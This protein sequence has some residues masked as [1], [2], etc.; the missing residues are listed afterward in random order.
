MK[1]L[2]PAFASLLTA[3]LASA[4]STAPSAPQPETKCPA[5]PDRLI[6]SKLPDPFTFFNGKKVRTKDDWA[7]RRAEISALLQRFELGDLPGKPDKVVGVIDENHRSIT[8]N[9]TVGDRE[10]SF[11]S[12]IRL[13]EPV[14]PEP[15]PSPEPEPEE[16]EEPSPEPEEPV[17]EPEEPEPTPEPEDPDSVST[18]KKKYPAIISLG[19]ASIPAPEGVAV[20]SLNNDLIA[21]Q[22]GRT[23]SRGKGLFYDLYGADHSAGAMLA[24]TWGVSRLIDALESAQGSQIDTKRLAVTGCSRNGKGTH[25]VGAFEE[26]IALTIPQ[27]PGTGGAGC[28]RIA[29]QLRDEG[30]TVQTGSQ[31]ITENVW[32][33]TRFDEYANKTGV[34]PFDHHFLSA[35]VAPRGLLVLEH[36]GIDWLGPESTYGCVSAAR[37]V[38]QALGAQRNVGFL[39]AGEHNHCQ[40]PESQRKDLEAYFDRFLK[41]K[42]AETGHFKTDGEFEWDES[43]WIDWETPRLR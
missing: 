18:P 5:F 25:V 7:C 3:L 27:E 13:P 31:I 23:R 2:T 34:L 39:Q 16:P 38:W 10:I 43:E 22:Q 4:Q 14:K 11:T 40:F 41:G 9:V 30:L 8:V 20:I 21:E 15:E 24:W 19:Y 12:T 35:M 42:R 32:F 29:D 28:W 17:P 6:L 33:S 36:S 1:I 37:K 26:R